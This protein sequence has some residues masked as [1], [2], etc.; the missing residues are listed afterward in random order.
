M[1]IPLTSLLATLVAKSRSAPPKGRTL[2]KWPQIASEPNLKGLQVLDNGGRYRI[3]TYDFHRVKLTSLEKSRIYGER[4]GALRNAFKGF[5]ATREQQ[6]E[7]NLE[8]RTSERL[9]SVYS[10][11]LEFSRNTT[12]NEDRKI[13][14]A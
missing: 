7:P 1:L 14:P 2:E 5:R 3:R 4:W 10:N 12:T 13:L 11:Q 8:P 6:V 9:A